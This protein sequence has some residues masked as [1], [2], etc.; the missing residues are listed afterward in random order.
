MAD[1][2]SAAAPS[3]KAPAG[4]ISRTAAV[5]KAL[6]TLGKDAMPMQIKGFIKDKFGVEMSN[7]A[8]SAYKSVMNRKEAKTNP[9]TKGPA[10]K[11]KM[12]PAPAPIAKKPAPAPA[13]KNPAQKPL[14]KPALATR[15]NAKAGKIELADIQAVKNLVGRVGPDQLKTLIDVLSK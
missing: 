2:M 14:S 3:K 10:Q 1:K 12:Q 11:P 15:S 4:S 5:T 6:A 13:A 9:A 8:V 7:N